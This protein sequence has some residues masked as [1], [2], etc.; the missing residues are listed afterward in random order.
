MTLINKH[1]NEIF[2][3]SH[4]RLRFIKTNTE[5]DFNW[6]FLPGGPGLG[7]ESLYPLTQILNL[8]GKMWHLDLPGDGSNRTSDDAEYFSHWS[9]ALIEAVDTFEKTI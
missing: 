2:T 9:Q 4:A 5:A 6:I 8:P 7:S 3:K 1:S